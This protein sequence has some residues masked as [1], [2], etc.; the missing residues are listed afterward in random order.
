MNNIIQTIKNT[1]LIISLISISACERE[2]DVVSFY[3]K[4]DISISEY[5]KSQGSTYSNFLK[6]IELGNLERTLTARNPLGAEYTLFLPTNDAFD[7][8]IEKNNNYN[9][10]QELLNDVDYI[11]QLLHFY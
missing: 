7:R 1:W 9:A 2:L 8:F 6:V 11:N 3:D 10:F 5:I 4:E